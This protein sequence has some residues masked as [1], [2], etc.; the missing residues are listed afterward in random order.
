MSTEVN[1]QT[2][3]E[4][5]LL[6]EIAIAKISAGIAIALSLVLI[7]FSVLTPSF[8]KDEHIT[9]IVLFKYC[10]SSFVGLF[11][12]FSLINII[13]SFIGVIRLKFK[14]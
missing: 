8:F 1:N 10:V 6:W 5:F 7:I 9:F 2:I 14:A 13:S 12:M 3:F 4:R 11:V